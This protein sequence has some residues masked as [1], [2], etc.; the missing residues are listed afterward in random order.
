MSVKKIMDDIRKDH[1]I[2]HSKG[3]PI[4]DE[5]TIRHA[6]LSDQL[7]RISLNSNMVMAIYFGFKHDGRVE[8]HHFGAA[9]EL[10]KR[11]AFLSEEFTKQLKGLIKRYD[12][13]NPPKNPK[14]KT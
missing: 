6:A 5:E 9:P 4:S 2:I 8:V 3:K 13:E 14:V 7:T 10:G 11:T 12:R 1:T